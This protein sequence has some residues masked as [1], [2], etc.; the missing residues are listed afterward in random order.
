MAK[1]VHQAPVNPDILSIL[2]PNPTRKARS[3]LQLGLVFTELA[4]P[5]H[6]ALVLK[7]FVFIAGGTQLVAL[8]HQGR[9]IYEKL[10]L[11]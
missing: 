9:L 4:S 10:N 5:E 6:G 7:R 2:S 11:R 8:Y 1:T 3:D